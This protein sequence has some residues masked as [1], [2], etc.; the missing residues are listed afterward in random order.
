MVLSLGMVA[1]AIAAVPSGRLFHFERSK[2]RNYVCYDVNL[3]Q[4]EALDTKSPVS[5][6][7]IRVEEGG[8]KKELSFFQRKFAFGYKVISRDT[9]EATIHLTAY[10]KLPIRICQRSGKWIALCTLHGKE[11]QITKMFAQMKSP[12]SLHCN[13]V[14][15]YGIDLST[16]GATRERI[17]ND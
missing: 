15:I 10:D 6:Y 5:V 3:K 2:N 16:G 14:D 17:N 12:N 4:G 7:W 13:Y 8:G 11:I 9:N 1:M